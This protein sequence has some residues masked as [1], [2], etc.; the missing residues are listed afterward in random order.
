[1]Y[2]VNL[3]AGHPVKSDASAASALHEF[4]GT[5]RVGLGSEWITGRTLTIGNWEE[6]L[7]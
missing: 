5:A 1:M 4:A 6:S 3:N 2:F 7:I